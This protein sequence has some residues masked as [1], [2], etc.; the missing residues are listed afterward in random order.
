MNFGILLID[1]PKDRTSFS[2]V[3]QIRRI[4]GIKKVG[5]TGTLDPF[6]TGLLPI[7]IGK[8]TKLVDKLLLDSKTYKVKM[9]FGEQTDTGD[10]T[11]EVK[12]IGDIPKS[13]DAEELRKFVLSIVSQIPP[14]YSALKVNGRRAYK[15]AR[16]NQDFELKPRKISIESC[17]IV[18][19]VAPYL[20]YR[21]RVSKGTY[22]RVLSESIANYLNTVG[23]TEELCREEISDFHLSSAIELESLTAENWHEHVLPVTTLFPDKSIIQLND[24]EV[25][26]YVNGRRFSI[27]RENGEEELVFDTNGKFLGFC[28][29]VEKMLHPKMV[30]ADQTEYITMDK[31]CKE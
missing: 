16:E 17:D 11:G 30:F 28:N 6:A 26:D 7:C 19:Y 13:I 14:K 20:T 31:E 12:V 18:E 3:A 27:E 10:N 29:V 5:H 21:V 15:L 23:V 2:V 1:K 24:N 4:T 25:L 9:R 22:I 8:A